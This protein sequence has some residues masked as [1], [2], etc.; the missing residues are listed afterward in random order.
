[1]LPLFDR[2]PETRWRKR[3]VATALASLYLLVFLL[4]WVVGRQMESIPPSAKMG[5][6][7]E[8]RIL[9]PPLGTEEPAEE[10]APGETVPRGDAPEGE[11][12]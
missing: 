10:A 11:G 7:L 4:A 5:P 6:A 9:P 12:P 3:P 2:K 8:E 1:M